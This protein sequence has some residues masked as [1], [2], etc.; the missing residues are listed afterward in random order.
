MGDWW[1]VAWRLHDAQFWGV[2]QRR[3]RIALVADF[4]GKSAPEILFERESMSRNIKQGEQEGKETTR[5]TRESTHQ[6]AY[7]LKIR[8]GAEIDSY[9]KRAGKG[10]LVQTEK[11]GTLGV[12]QD[13]TLITVGN[14]YSIDEKM[15]QTY[16]HEDQG[17]TLG[18]RDYKQPQAVVYGTYQDKVGT[19]SPGAHAGSYNGQDAYN[20]MLIIGGGGTEPTTASKASFFLNGRSDGKSDTLV[21]TDYKDPQIVAY[22]NKSSGNN[23]TIVI[24]GNGQ[25]ESHKGDG[26]KEADIMYTLNTIE[27]HAVCAYKKSE[28]SLDAE[29]IPC[30]AIDRAAFNQGKNAKYDFSVQEEIAQPLLAKGP[31]GGT[32]TV[33]AL[34]ARDYKGVGNQYVDEGKVI[35]QSNRKSSK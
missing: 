21:A 31:G 35:V 2:P 5:D 7:T 30:I 23:K 1:S 17:N 3:K 4:G 14:C 19:L 28:T 13:Q 8:G 22:E 9:G 34:C 18:A 29:N 27:Q 11:S 33:G 26:Y 6:S 16:I 10:A 15:G 12:S 20:D 25:R 24:E 32:D